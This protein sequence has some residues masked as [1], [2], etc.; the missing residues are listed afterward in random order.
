MTD[1][2]AKRPVANLRIKTIGTIP[3]YL[4]FTQGALDRWLG[5]DDPGLPATG[6]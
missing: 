4:S 1:L 3:G 6:E 2:P 5:L